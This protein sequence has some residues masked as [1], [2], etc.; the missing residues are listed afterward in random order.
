MTLQILINITI[1][2]TLF[3]K[4][5]KMS[6]Y[7]EKCNKSYMPYYPFFVDK[8]IKIQKI[9]DKIYDKNIKSNNLNYLDTNTDLSEIFLNS[10]NNCRKCAIRK[11]YKLGNILWTNT[12]LHKIKIHKSYPS[13]YF[14]KIILTMLILNDYIINPPIQLKSTQID[15]FTYIPLHHNKLL[16]IDALMYQGSQP[17]YVVPKNKNGQKKYIYSE[18]SG[19]ISVKNKIVENIIV[20]AQTNRIDI[21]DDNIYLPINTKILAEHEYIFHTHPNTSTYGGRVKE[22]IIYEFPSANDLFNFIKFHNE[23]KA[24]ASIIVAPEGIYV[25]RPIVYEHV[26]NIDY[27]FFYR[28]RK[29][30]LK[31]EKMAM[32]KFKFMIDKISEPDVFHNFIGSD[33]SFTKIYN[34]FIEPSNLFVEFYPRIKR[35]NEWSL[36]QIYLSYVS[37]KQGDRLY[38]INDI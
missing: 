1:F 24:Q 18:H 9:S 34:K 28:L 11:I 13:E 19:A 26:F 21:S 14:I 38:F 30:I 8:L 17:R 20:S 7:Y 23:G 6:Y 22:G 32:K 5:E 29:F 36:R 37:K 4:V 2:L 31:L 16:I 15:N 3:K 27:D 35:N 10:A 12:I 25:I 33:I